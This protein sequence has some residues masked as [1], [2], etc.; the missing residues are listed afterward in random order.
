VKLMY[1]VAAGKIA[2]GA[3]PVGVWE[4][5]C[6]ANPE[7]TPEEVKESKLALSLAWTDAR[8]ASIRVRAGRKV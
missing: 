4:E 5:H 2:A 3:S 1:E 7:M 6:A 8:K